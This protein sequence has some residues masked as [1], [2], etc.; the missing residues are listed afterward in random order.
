MGS[1]GEPIGQVDHEDG[2]DRIRLV[3]DKNGQHHWINW[4]MVERVEAEKVLLNLSAK[5]IHDIW[6]HDPSAH[7]R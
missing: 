2:Q 3:K 5:A 1:D 4:N 7:I 6:R